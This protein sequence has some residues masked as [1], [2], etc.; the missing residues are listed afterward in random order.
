MMNSRY[1]TKNYDPGKKV[2]E[3]D[4]EQL[5]E[6]LRLSA[7]SINSQPWKFTFVKDEGIKKQLAE[8]SYFNEERVSKASDLVI[9]SV[10]SSPDEFRDNIVEYLP[11]AKVAFYD[12]FLKPQGEGIVKNWMAHQVYL[13]LGFFL[14]ACASMGIDSTPMEGIDTAKYKEIAGL[15][16]H[17]PLFAV[18]IGY[19]DAED[20]N[21]PERNAKSRLEQELVINEL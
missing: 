12:N 6:V 8:A 13:A 11:E 18:A 17:D 14:S 2:S 21:Q 9:F 19:R 16:S 10:L 15:E 5:K 4:I 20:F 1:T 3:E 7:S